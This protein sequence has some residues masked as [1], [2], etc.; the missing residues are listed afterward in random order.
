METE[1]L[2]NQ[3]LDFSCTAQNGEDGTLT[4]VSMILG[5][6]RTSAAAI[7]SSRRLL[8]HFGSAAALTQ[9]S[10]EEIRRFGRVSAKQAV[11]LW[12]ALMLGRQVCCEPLRAGQR[13]S[14]SR[15]LFQRYRA[16]FFS[17]N[18]EYFLSLHLN[19][20]NQLIREVLVSVCS[21][22]TSIVHPREV[23]SPAVRDS[24][25]AV[26]LLHNHPS[27]DPVPSKEDKDCTS[28]LYQAGK[29]LG[30]RVLDHIVFGHDDYF[31]FADAGLLRDLE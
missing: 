21:L 28:R 4:L 19:S 9:S 2:G 26:I 11:L 17:A 25:A 1:K 14:N 7:A 18:K 23:F 31:S 22:S 13:F 29:I 20:K 3:S 6:G 10:V 27:G 24:T 5:L 12:A 8:R 15:D 16:Q 30:I